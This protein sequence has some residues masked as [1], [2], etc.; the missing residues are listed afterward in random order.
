[1][2][3]PFRRKNEQKAVGPLAAP[4]WVGKTNRS[5]WRLASM[6]CVLPGDTISVGTLVPGSP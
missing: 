1:M 6:I 3:G 5:S 2:W 4:R